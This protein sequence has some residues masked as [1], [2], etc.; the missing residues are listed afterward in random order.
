MLETVDRVVVEYE[1]FKVAAE[2]R[3]L[4]FFGSLCGC[5]DKPVA[6]DGHIG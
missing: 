5:T 4:S 1:V 3:I 6:G 2:E